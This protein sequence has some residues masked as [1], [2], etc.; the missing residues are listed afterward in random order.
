MLECQSPLHKRKA[1][2]LKTFWRRF[3]G[4]HDVD[5]TVVRMD[6]AAKKDTIWQLD[7]WNLKRYRSATIH[8]QSYCQWRF[9]AAVSTSPD[10]QGFSKSIFQLQF[11]TFQS[12]WISNNLPPLVWLTSGRPRSSWFLSFGVSIYQAWVETGVGGG[13]AGG[14]T[15]PPKVLIWWKYEQNPFNSGQNLWKFGQN[16]WKPS[17]NCC[18]VWI[19]KNGTQSIVS[20]FLFT[21]NFIFRPGWAMPPRFLLGSR[22]DP[23]V[24]FLISCVR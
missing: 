1:P 19:Y 18:V 7:W 8:F 23:P 15:A 4:L 9:F 3:W 21:Q 14:A 24:F 16:V 6:T 2:L 13:G 12:V 11:E 20:N 22:F 5:G 17:Q 10:L